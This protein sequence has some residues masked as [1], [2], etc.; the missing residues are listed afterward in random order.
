MI[1]IL[2]IACMLV[3]AHVHGILSCKRSRAMEQHSSN[4]D[5]DDL[6]PQRSFHRNVIRKGRLALAQ[7][8]SLPTPKNCL[9]DCS[10]EH[11]WYA[12]FERSTYSKA[13]Q[14]APM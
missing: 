11:G 9:N 5:H 2:Q 6:K 14:T 1:A 3:G 12:T 4:R 7:R 10:R 13:D 8:N